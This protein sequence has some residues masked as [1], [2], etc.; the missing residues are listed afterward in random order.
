MGEW[1][2]RP[3][4]Q[5]L[6]ELGTGAGGLTAREAAKRLDSHGP[7][8]LRSPPGPSLLLRVLADSGF[9]GDVIIEPYAYQTEDGDALRAPVD[10][11]RGVIER[12]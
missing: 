12:L 8:E 11:M 6:K 9:A 10:W 7:N 5:I 2:S 1:H 3:A 4:A